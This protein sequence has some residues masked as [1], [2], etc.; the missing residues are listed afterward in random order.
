[1]VLSEVAK[2][3]YPVSRGSS[4]WVIRWLGLAD[5]RQSIECQSITDTTISI[6]VHIHNYFQVKVTTEPYIHVF[7]NRDRKSIKLKERP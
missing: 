7:E 1:M 3:C 4:I 6:G 5:I 2:L